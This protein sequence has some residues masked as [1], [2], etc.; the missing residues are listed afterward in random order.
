M[1]F[2]T[3]L[4]LLLAVMTVRAF[5]T[6]KQINEIG[7]EIVDSSIIQPRR[8]ALDLEYVSRSRV[9]RLAAFLTQLFFIQCITYKDCCGLADFCLLNLCRVHKRPKP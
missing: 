3:V 8:C 7:D 4:V 1:R 6:M 5:K 9:D 2:E